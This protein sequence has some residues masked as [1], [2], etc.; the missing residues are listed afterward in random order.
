MVVTKNMHSIIE[1]NNHETS[2]LR[3]L[4]EELGAMNAMREKD[5]GKALRPE[6]ERLRADLLFSLPSQ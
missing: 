5:G 2:L 3:E 4:L 6:L 1:F